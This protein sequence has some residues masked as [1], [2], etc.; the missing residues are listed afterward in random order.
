MQPWIT[1]SIFIWTNNSAVVDEYTLG[2]LVDNDV[3]LAMLKQHWETWITE[4]DFVAI[5]AAGLNH[6]RYVSSSVW[7]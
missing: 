1:P 5:K 2:K 6:V 4:D 3:A 7:S